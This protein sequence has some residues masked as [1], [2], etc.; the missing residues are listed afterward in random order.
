MSKFLTTA[1]LAQTRKRL[2]RDV[3]YLVVGGGG[4]GR[5]APEINRR[6][7][8][9][10]GAGGYVPGN[11][12]IA[13]G[14][15]D[16]I[17]GGPA[18]DS[19]FLDI[20]AIRGGE[21]SLVGFGGSNATVGGSG[22]GGGYGITS[23]PDTFL[24]AAGT[25]GQ[26]NEG[27]DGDS[28]NQTSGGNT[29]GA[30]GGGASSKG[31]LIA[32][33]NDPSEFQRVSRFPNA[34]NGLQWLDGNWYAGGGGGSKGFGSTPSGRTGGLGGGGNGQRTLSDSSGDG[35][36]NTGGGGGASNGPSS[37]NFG[38][39]LGGSGIVVVRY[40]GTPVATGGNI[41]QNGGYTYHYFNESGQFIYL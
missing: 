32:H 9:G 35:Q 15:Y 30:G 6:G 40:A 4:P 36:P 41:V 28:G 38:P 3:D 37:S 1:T 25:P 22:G 34:G 5:W 18:Q 13:P 2:L 11:T 27:G 17:V 24:G 26:G 8:G 39:R 7:I 10:G 16:I 14:V 31:G 19:Q 29:A 23:Q 20:I 12:D 33:L 21:G